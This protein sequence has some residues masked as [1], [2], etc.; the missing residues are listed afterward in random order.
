MGDPGMDD[1]DL[2]G[3]AFD[4]IAQNNRIDA[5]VAGDLC[6]GLQAILRGVTA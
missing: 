4:G 1:G 5:K 2:A 3:F 6:C